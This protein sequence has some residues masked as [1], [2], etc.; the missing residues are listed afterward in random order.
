M[1]RRSDR[2][3]STDDIRAGTAKCRSRDESSHAVCNDGH[4]RA[5]RLRLNCAQLPYDGGCVPI[6]VLP[7]W[8]EIYRMHG[9]DASRA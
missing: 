1:V 6:E 5:L 9:A 7:E 4:A 8:L 3:Y 2:H